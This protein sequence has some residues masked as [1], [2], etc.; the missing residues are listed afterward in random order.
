MVL[1]LPMFAS[2]GIGISCC[3]ITAD[4]AAADDDANLGLSSTVK[5]EDD[6]NTRKY[7]ERS[8]CLP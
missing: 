5:P 4:A 1:L 8:R 3:A 2:V 6:D 7:E